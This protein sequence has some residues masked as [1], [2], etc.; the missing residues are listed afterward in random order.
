[1]KELRKHHSLKRCKAVHSQGK[2]TAT[3]GGDT[4][5]QAEAT[6]T[7]VIDLNGS[8]ML[9]QGKAKRRSRKQINMSDLLQADSP[10]PLQ[11]T[12]DVTAL[13]AI[14]QGADATMLDLTS[15]SVSLLNLTSSSFSSMNQTALCLS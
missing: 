12:L 13:T 5:A 4:V 14:T 6:A 7:Y 10:V 2:T 8:T 3:A 11:D 15:S 9:K 1:M